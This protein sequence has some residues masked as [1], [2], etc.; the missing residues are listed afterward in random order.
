MGKRLVRSNLDV[1]GSAVPVVGADDGVV[2]SDVPVVRSNDDV[3]RSD[4]PV[5]RPDDD[6]VG[7]A[8][9]PGRSND[10]VVRSAV[11]LVRSGDVVAGSDDVVERS[12][13]PPRARG[14]PLT[15]RVG[16]FSVRPIRRVRDK[17]GFGPWLRGTRCLATCP[18]QETQMNTPTTPRSIVTL[19][20]PRRVP[21]LI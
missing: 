3:V 7:P 19:A 9:P 20:F 10:D 16:L 14:P 12:A 21:A 8:V 18:Q 5:V 6:V 15:R 11:P 17:G 2:G 13:V 4:V 1:V